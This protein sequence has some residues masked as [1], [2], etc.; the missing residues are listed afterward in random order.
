MCERVPPARLYIVGIKDEHHNMLR[1]WSERVDRSHVGSII[2][3]GD[4]VA[5]IKGLGD[6][7]RTEYSVAPAVVFPR[8]C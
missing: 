8:D 3:N 6:N 5:I 7:T 4:N 1:F 2:W